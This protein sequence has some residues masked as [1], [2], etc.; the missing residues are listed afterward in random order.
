MSLQNH[1][2]MAAEIV[3][4]RSPSLRMLPTVQTVFSK[5]LRI[6]M[7]QLRAWFV[8]LRRPR[9]PI[10]RN[11]DRGPEARQRKSEARLDANSRLQ[12]LARSPERSKNA[13]D[14]VQRRLLAVRLEG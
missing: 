5:L 9:N 6:L 8:Q 10:L 4:T 12:M 7:I 13:Q 1:W 2:P 3:L 11:L 14:H